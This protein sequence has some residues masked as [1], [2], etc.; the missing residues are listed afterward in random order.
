M[1]HV[2]LAEEFINFI[3]GCRGDLWSVHNAEPNRFYD[4]GFTGAKHCPGD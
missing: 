3:D 1:N 4:R 2:D